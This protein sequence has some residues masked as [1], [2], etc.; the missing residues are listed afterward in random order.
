MT[1]RQMGRGQPGSGSQEGR[2]RLVSGPAAVPPQAVA[3]YDNRSARR[4]GT[5]VT[6]AAGQLWSA[7]LAAAVIMV[8]VGV[9]MLAWPT[10]TLHVVAVLVGIALLVTGLFRLFDGFSANWETT[11][12]RV[13]SVVIGLLAIIAGL[14]AV[15]N[16]QVTVLALALVVGVFWVAQGITDI[17][18]AISAG[19]FPGRGWI[20]FGGILGV[21]A[22]IIVLFWPGISVLVLVT[23]LAIWLIV[24]GIVLAVT[25]FQVR[26]SVRDLT[27]QAAMA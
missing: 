1:E 11:G 7:T 14:Y 10:A 15:R 2:E 17:A 12:W 3:G 19:P 16:H 20:A 26:S 8:A 22:G 21:T 9:I 24:Y 13:A 27:A 4:A 6:Q 25:A 18:I 5:T 23:V